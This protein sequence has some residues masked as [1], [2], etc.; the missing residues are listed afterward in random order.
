METTQ[1][2]A[3]QETAQEEG[4][5]WSMKVEPTPEHL[6]LQ[7]FL[8]EWEAEA[9]EGGCGGG[10]INFRSLGQA[11]LVG[12]GVMDMPDGDKGYS[13]ITL[14]F[15]PDAGR[16]VGSWVGSMMTHHWVYDG[17]LDEA[18]KVLSLE[19]TGP[20][21]TEPGKMI[22]YKDVITV[23]SDDHHTLSGNLQKEDGSWE[24]FMVTHY[25]R[26]K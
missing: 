1:E 10:A 12:D 13:Q 5:E 6:W 2:V 21:W 19:S 14:G 4:Q 3:Q 25:R 9:G 26:K 18:K 15:N 23:I 8:G 22:P 11:W 24:Q 7:Q 20:S 16:F 17:Y